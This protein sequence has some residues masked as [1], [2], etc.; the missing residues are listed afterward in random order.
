MQLC[1]NRQEVRLE[2]QT[3]GAVTGG[4]VGLTGQSGDLLR[5]IDGGEFEESLGIILL[6]RRL[7]LHEVPDVIEEVELLLVLGLQ[8]RRLVLVQVHHELVVGA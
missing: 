5:P 2:A 6:Q 1:V 3:Q 4:R 8:L 7:L